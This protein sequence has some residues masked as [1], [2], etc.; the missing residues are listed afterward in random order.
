MFPLADLFDGASI[1]VQHEFGHLWISYLNVPP[2]AAAIP[3]WP[4]STMASGTMGFSI[5]PTGEGGNFPCLIVPQPA[6]VRLVPNPDQPVYGDMDLYLMGLCAIEAKP[7]FSMPPEAS[8]RCYTPS[9][10]RKSG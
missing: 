1:G 7:L 5:P 2:L 9:E 10:L 4:F 3:H 8:R 6:G